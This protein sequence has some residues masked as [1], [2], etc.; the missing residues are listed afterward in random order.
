MSG[1]GGTTRGLRHALASWMSFKMRSSVAFLIVQA[2]GQE[3]RILVPLEKVG[4]PGNL[5][6]KVG[7]TTTD[8]A[9]ARVAQQRQD[10]ILF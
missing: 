7:L 1:Y 8:D 5:P 4:K 9:Q 10:H 6:I 3:Y 2:G